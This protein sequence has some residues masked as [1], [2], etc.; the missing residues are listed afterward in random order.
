MH[1]CGFSY[2]DFT[3]YFV[4]F[5]ADVYHLQ[6][7]D[8]GSLFHGRAGSRIPK[9]LLFSLGHLPFDLYSCF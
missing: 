7:V 5:G 2:S 9:L 6:F 4:K 3:T 8:K 1:M